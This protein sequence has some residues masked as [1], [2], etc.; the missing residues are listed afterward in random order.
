M[1]AVAVRNCLECQQHA[2]MKPIGDI[3][4]NQKTVQG[5]VGAANSSAKASIRPH[6]GAQK[7]VV[8]ILYRGI[9]F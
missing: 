6:S 2:L 5:F 7:S 9:R 1:C 4:K 8:T 3:V